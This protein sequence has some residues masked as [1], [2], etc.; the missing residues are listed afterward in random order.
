MEKKLFW[1]LNALGI[2]ALIAAILGGFEVWKRI[3]PQTIPQEWVELN[4]LL[5]ERWQNRS[6]VLLP[7]EKKE[8]LVADDVAAKV[9]IANHIE[10]VLLKSYKRFGGKADRAEYIRAIAEALVDSTKSVEE[11]FW[12]CGMMQTESS[13][14]LSAKPGKSS[15]SSARGFLQVITRY[16]GDVLNPANITKKDLETDIEKSVLG[17]VLVFHKYRYTRRGERT[18][19]EATRR[20][21]SLA[22]SE[23]EQQRYFNSANKVFQKLMKDFKE[24][25]KK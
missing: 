18:V 6:L 1:A 13:F 16:H 15:N 5:E 20:Y 17:G 24:V 19:A 21:R 10:T 22:V 2:A 14:R 3:Q 12:I 9:V 23:T 25:K 11:S 4:K 7:P 8:N